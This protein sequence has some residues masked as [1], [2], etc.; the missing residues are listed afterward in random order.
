MCRI[1]RPTRGGE[2]VINTEDRRERSG[3]GAPATAIRCI[4]ARGPAL[5]R[6]VLMPI[7]TGR[8]PPRQGVSVPADSSLFIYAVVDGIHGVHG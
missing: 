4:G 1:T 3:C 7:K 5:A 8:R 2:W 6:T